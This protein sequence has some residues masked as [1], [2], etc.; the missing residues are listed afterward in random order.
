MSESVRGCQQRRVSTPAMTSCPKNYS[1]EDAA[2]T[3]LVQIKPGEGAFV[4][5]SARLASRA[6][7]LDQTGHMENVIGIQDNVNQLR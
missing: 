3:R 2:Q 4:V 6:P 1:G 7:Q 5:H